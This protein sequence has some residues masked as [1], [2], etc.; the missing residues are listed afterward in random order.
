LIIG[1][2]MKIIFVTGGTRSGKSAFAVK[3]AGKLSGKKAYIAT[4]EVLDEEMK[5]R[6]DKHRKERGSKWQTI[7]EPLKISELIKQITDKYSVIVLD[8]LTLWLSNLMLSGIK[9][10]NEFDKLAET[11]KQLKLSTLNSQLFIISNEVGMGIVPENKLARQFRD[12]AGTLNQKVAEISDGVYMV[13][14]G[15]PIK[16]K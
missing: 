15:I 12:L 6:V 13:A 10:E 16:I 14:S 9:I 7:E 1:E 3:E 11:L 8:C 2:K 4:T 5:V